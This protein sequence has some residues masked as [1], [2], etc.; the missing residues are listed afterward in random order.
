MRLAVSF[1]L[2]ASIALGPSTQQKIYKKDRDFPKTGC[3]CGKKIVDF[4]F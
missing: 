1:L 4:F 3:K 2:L